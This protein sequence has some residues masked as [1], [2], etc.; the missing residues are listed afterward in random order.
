M[1]KQLHGFGR[2]DPYPGRLGVIA[3]AWKRSTSFRA[4]ASKPTGGLVAEARR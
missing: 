4:Y 3:S 2:S 1:D